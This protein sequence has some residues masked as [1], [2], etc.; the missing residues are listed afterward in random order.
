MN[1]MFVGI[2]A[3][4]TIMMGH[5]N[6][7]IIV[8]VVDPSAVPAAR[9][10]SSVFRDCGHSWQNRV[11]PSHAMASACSI[12]EGQRHLRSPRQRTQVLTG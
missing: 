4:S 9:G 6:K 3:E 2:N 7:C 10:D 12:S 5:T 1:S 8:F 11:L